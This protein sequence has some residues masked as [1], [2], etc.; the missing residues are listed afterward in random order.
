MKKELAAAALLLLIFC[1]SLWHLRHLRLL[2]D[3]LQ[4]RTDL[5]TAAAEASQ[6][7][8]AAAASDALLLRWQNA[9][10][11]TQV[12]I[13]HPDIDAVSD[14]LVSLISAVRSQDADACRTAAFS[15]QNRLL[16][17][18]KA[19]TPTLGSIF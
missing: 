10:G 12:F 3:E 14:A 1:A 8:I 15:I 9:E 6:W 13:R 18:R 5:T 7:D 16:A 17:I 4:T 11:Y 2:L 19:E